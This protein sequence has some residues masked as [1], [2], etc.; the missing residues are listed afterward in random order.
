MPCIPRVEEQSFAPSP[1][2]QSLPSGITSHVIYRYLRIA[3]KP[4]TKK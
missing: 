2:L 4:T 1:C 3:K